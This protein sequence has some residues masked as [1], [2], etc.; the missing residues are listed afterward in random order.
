[1]H[2]HSARP[3]GCLQDEH[4]PARTACV[5]VL[6]RNDKALER[7]LLRANPDDPNHQYDVHRTSVVP[8]DRRTLT[9]SKAK[10]FQYIGLEPGDRASQQQCKPACERR[11]IK[12]EGF[13]CDHFLPHSGLLL[14]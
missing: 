9:K 14:N 5:K 3:Y 4:R 8:L 11:W 2:R 10:R 1:M 13:F 6:C 7:A 12:L